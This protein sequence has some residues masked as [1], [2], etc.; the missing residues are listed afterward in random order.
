[1]GAYSPLPFVTAEDER[2]A[3][4]KIMQPVADAMIAEGVPSEGVLYGGLMKTARGY[5]VIEFNARF[6]D[7]ETEGG[8]CRA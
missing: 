8:C 4:E 1:M 2:Y 3:L 6:G 5:Q 7:P